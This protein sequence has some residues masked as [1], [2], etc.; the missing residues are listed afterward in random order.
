M[1]TREEA[2]REKEH[3]TQMD[4]QEKRPSHEY[5]K[6]VEHEVGVPKEKEIKKNKPKM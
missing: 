6:A 5:R 4:Y 2:V 1:Q 3:D